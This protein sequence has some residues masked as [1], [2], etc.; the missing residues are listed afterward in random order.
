MA[1]KQGCPN[2]M[3][4]LAGMYERGEGVTQSSEEAMKLFTLA[5][6]QRHATAQYNLGVFYE[7]G[8]GVAESYDRASKMYTLAATQG[9]VE[10]QYMLGWAYIRGVGVAQSNAMARKWWLKAALRENKNAIQNLKRLDKREGKTKPTLP[11]C[12][13]CGT[14][15][16]IRLPFKLCSQCHTTQYCNRDCQMSHWKEGHKRECKRLKAAAE[17]AAAAAKKASLPKNKKEDDANKKEVAVDKEC[18]NET[19][20]PSRHRQQQLNTND[21]F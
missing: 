21:T 8:K 11:C 13:A 4:D 12:A 19:S 9:H 14:N 2:A 17:A 10:S 15:K 1:V 16:T 3:F 18:A 7:T 6:N 20:T 5:A